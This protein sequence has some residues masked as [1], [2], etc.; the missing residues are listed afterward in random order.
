MIKLAPVIREFEKRRVN[1]KIVASNQNDL[2]F[3]ELKSLMNKQSEDYRLIIKQTGRPKNIYL[4]FIYWTVKTFGN[5]LLYFRNEFKS[6]DKNKTY[7]I[8]HGDTISSLMGAVIAK[9]NRVKLVHVESGLRSFNF[10]EPFPEEISRYIISLLSDIHF[11]PNNWSV[12]NLKTRGSVKVNTRGNTVGESINTVLSKRIKIDSEL[13]KEKYFILVLHRQEHTLFNKEGTKKLIKSIIK[14]TDSKLKCVFVMHKL[15]QD[16]LKSQNI[17]TK[18]K[19]DPRVVFT[20]RLSYPSFVKLMQGSEFIATD[21]GSNQEE[22]Y[23]LGL[24]CLILRNRT[25]RIEGLKSNAVLSKMDEKVIKSFLRNYKKY[26][27][28]AVN[29]SKGFPS[30]VIVDFLINFR[31]SGNIPF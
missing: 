1:F 19:K 31:N 11:C 7:F 16:Y 9:L 15:T 29:F 27:R 21:G 4:S 18:I 23:F 24:P 5:F 10:F 26:Q 17:Y 20:S 12:K 13:I 3:E 2:R 25:E 6:I 14:E 22:A 30:K 8:V 28:P